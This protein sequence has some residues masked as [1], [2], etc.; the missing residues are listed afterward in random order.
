MR[1]RDGVLV[2]IYVSNKRLN[3]VNRTLAEFRL[4]PG[5]S[6]SRWQFSTDFYERCLVQKRKL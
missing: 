2:Y 6:F 4:Y 3:V 1:C 5:E